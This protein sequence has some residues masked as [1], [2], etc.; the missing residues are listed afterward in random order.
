MKYK[1][2]ILFTAFIF[3]LLA[4]G[5]V[6]AAGNN[7]TINTT[8]SSGLAITDWPSFQKDDNKTG[9]SNHTGPKTNTTKW[10]YSN[11]TVKGSA[12]VGKNSN[13]HVAGADGVLYTFGSTGKL[14]W[15]Y[16]TRSAI[17]GSPTIG[18]DGTIYISNWM[19]SSTYAISSNGSLKWKYTTGDYNFGS[20]PVIGSDGMVYVV[21][22]N[23][24]NGKLYAIDSNGKF[25]WS[26]TTGKVYG[27]SPLIGSGTI[28]IADYD[29]VLYAL[30]RDGKLKWS[31]R[32][33]YKLN[34]VDYHVNIYYNSL[35]RGSDGTIYLNS[36]N[37]RFIS[38]VTD[39]IRPKIGVL[40]AITDT[41]TDCV[42]KGYNFG[43]PLYGVP[44]ISSNGTVY[45]LGAGGLHALY[46]GGS[47]GGYK[48][49]ISGPGLTSVI[50][51]KN[52]TIYFGSSTGLIALNSNGTVKWTYSMGD[53]AG[54]PAISGD[55]TL[56]IG[57]TSG[58][59]YAL[60]DIAAN[61]T[62][63]P[64]KG[65][66]L[67]VKFTGNTTGK[68]KS[69]KWDFGDGTTSTAQ[70]PNHTYGKAG[71]YT[72]T[73]T[74]VL[75]NGKAT[76]IKKVVV[77]KQD[78]VAPTVTNSLKSGTYE[79][80]HKA[81]L[82]AKDD[83]T[84]VIYYTTNGGSPLTSSMRKIYTSALIID[85]STLLKYA[86]VDSFG[87]WSPVY[88]RNYTILDVVYVKDASSYNAK[89]INQDIQAI[90]DGA[91]PG[92][93]VIFKGQ[94]YSNLALVLNKKLSIIS[95]VGTKIVTNRS[96]SV[97]FRFNG[98]KA[99]GSSITGFTIVTDTGS[100]ILV[101]GAHDVNISSVK[102]SSARGTAITVK[103]SNRT[104]IKN[105]SI[106]NSS[107]GIHVYKSN[108]TTI[109]ENTIKGNGLS[110]GDGRSG[111]YLEGS[112]HVKVSD[113]QITENWYG[114]KTNDVL[115]AKI[116]GNTIYRNERDG[117]LLTGYIKNTNIQSNTVDG[118]NNAI[119]INGPDE[120]LTIQSNLLI[121]SRLVK[122]VD[123]TYSGDGLL[124]GANSRYST[125]LVLNNNI[126]LQ[127]EHRDFETRYAGEPIEDVIGSNLSRPGCGAS[128]HDLCGPECQCKR[129]DP[130]IQMI[131]TRTGPNTFT[132]WFRNG[133]TNTTITD[134]PSFDATFIMGSN[135]KTVKAENGTATMTYDGS[136][137]MGDVTAKAFDQTASISVFS[138]LTGKAKEL[139]NQIVEGFS[140]LT[141]ASA[142]NPVPGADK[143]E[144]STG[145][146]F[147]PVYGSGS[148]SSSVSHGNDGASTGTQ[149]VGTEATE[150]AQSAGASYAQDMGSSSQGSQSSTVQELILDEN[151]PGWGILAVILLI[152]IVSGVYYRSDL[153]NMVEKS[154]K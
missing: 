149:T 89:T 92:S 27:T 36:H 147:S 28:Y 31:N 12:V 41:G 54:S 140:D 145:S 113:S 144:S 60:N 15:T 154:R 42:V 93:K 70:S 83:S 139:I 104:T 88:T 152:I 5:S 46:T 23:D 11:L 9:Q 14:L 106:T 133:I 135:S 1:N 94:T 121:N 76:R 134:L 56:Y 57:S 105:S 80:T 108:Y 50:L 136:N 102:V 53:V 19:N 6:S 115:G 78:I 43:E 59:F 77:V 96:G 151:S 8:N 84:T 116:Y 91:N 20:S 111:V 38:G 74:V 150:S 132:L 24:F 71:V 22:S 117:I 143:G 16:T 4:V 101:D 17:Y 72:V 112:N 2:L 62:A 127:N 35:S 7:S 137:F 49:V 34:N 63:N 58:V 13:V 148:G 10:T 85:D 21:A 32:L 51:G 153:M 114:I 142:D 37:G 61:F 99:S 138:E 98:S 64:V 39:E 26:Y 29:G 124:F 86:A 68:A 25:K 110:G 67:T 118:N 75:E 44:A 119:H 18:T 97:I 146:G 126:I 48:T 95:K 107:T 45:V 90:L 120:N 52:G 65:T 123:K 87:N 109:T 129:W 130:E 66:K 82:K 125:S 128:S 73:L 122:G 69:W 33:I 40:F 3:L 79:S 47:I 141:G 100:G 131:L 30:T 103:G 55:G 81:T